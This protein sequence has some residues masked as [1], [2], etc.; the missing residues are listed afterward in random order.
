MAQ[1]KAYLVFCN[2]CKED[3]G[4]AQRE[5]ATR[6]QG[7]GPTDQRAVPPRH[8]C[9]GFPP[10]LVKRVWGIRHLRYLWYGVQVARWVNLRGASHAREA[11]LAYLDAVWEGRA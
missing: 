6:Q 7:I 8:E 1:Q 4:Y 9:R 3:V 2:L 11:D 5:L 10:V